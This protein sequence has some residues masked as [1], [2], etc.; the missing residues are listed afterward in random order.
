MDNKQLDALIALLEGVNRGERLENAIINEKELFTECHDV[1]LLLRLAS[2]DQFDPELWRTVP[3]PKVIDLSCLVGSDVLCEFWTHPEKKDLFRGYLMDITTSVGL[4]GADN[5]QQY[6]YC[7][8]ATMV[9]AWQGGECPL[10]E[11]VEVMIFSRNMGE[12]ITAANSESIDW[13]FTDGAYCERDIMQYQVTGTQE[14][15]VLPHEVKK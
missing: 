3:K 6:M 12:R 11:G 2:I 5:A 15:Y 7:Q 4:Y 10:P 9:Q 8:P 14:G 13:K 1:N